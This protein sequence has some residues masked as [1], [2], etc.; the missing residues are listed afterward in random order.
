MFY[1]SLENREKIYLDFITV[2]LKERQD[3]RKKFIPDLIKH[4]KS[5]WDEIFHDSNLTKQ[6]IIDFVKYL[7]EYSSTDD[8]KRLENVDSL[9]G[10]L[11]NIENPISTGASLS[12]KKA[13]KEF[14]IDQDVKFKVLEKPETLSNSFFDFVVEKNSY[15]INYRNVITILKVKLS[16][17]EE[18]DIQKAIYSYITELE[19]SDLKKYLEENINE[20]VSKVLLHENGSHSESEDSLITLLNDQ[21][22]GTELKKKLI[23]IQKSRISSLDKLVDQEAQEIVTS[24]NKIEATWENVFFYYDQFDESFLNET[25]ITFLN[26]EANHTSLSKSSVFTI[27]GVEREKLLKFRDALLYCSGLNSVAYRSI[28]KSLRPIESVD[29]SKLNAEKARILLEEGILDLNIHNYNGLKS[30]EGVLHIE[31]IEKHINYFIK[32]TNSFSLDNPDWQLILSSDKIKKAQKKELLPYLTK[33][34][35]SDKEVAKL[36]LK[37]HPN[38]KIGEYGF[39]EVKVLLNHQNSIKTRISIL[40]K[41]INDLH[42]DQL[43]VIVSLFGIAYKDL[44]GLWK[45]PSFPNNTEHQMLL[46]ELVERGII[47]SYVKEGKT[48]RAH[49]KRK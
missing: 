22:L 17:F 3:S 48:L 4:R 18:E 8:L 45:M 47:S 32:N 33:E 24:A 5:F 26:N 41:Y 19:L 37:L 9:R 13:L 10:Y 6:E 38:Q 31:L 7:F 49:C 44:F 21:S 28:L 40:F 2:F 36:V 16:E 34:E 29:F 35:L 14:I 11:D 1:N 46:E 27:D 15:L 39:D 30:I 25:I 23:S 20:F 42:D 12:D 43:G